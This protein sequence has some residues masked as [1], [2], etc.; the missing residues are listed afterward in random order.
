M[1][2][3]LRIRFFNVI[4]SYFTTYCLLLTAHCL[5]HFF[6]TA[7]T[8]RKL[9]DVSRLKALG[10]EA[11]ADLREGIEKTYKWFQNNY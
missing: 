1:N 9:L 3:A 7:W 8:P 10:W 4:A 5:L 2:G 11:K 6:K